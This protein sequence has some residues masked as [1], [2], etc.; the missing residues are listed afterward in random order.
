M[1][2]TLII[3]L[4]I[5][6]ILAILFYVFKDEIKK[7]FVQPTETI[8]PAGEVVEEAKQPEVVAQNLS[9]PWEL[10]FLPGGDM[11]VTERAGKLIR[12]GTDK[13]IIEIS[14]VTHKGEGGLLGLALHPNFK[15]NNYIYVYLTTTSSK[16][17]TN[18]VERYILV[19]E[20]L[21]ERKVIIENIPGA[22][23]HDGG[24]IAFGPDGFLYITTGDAGDKKNSQDK[25]SL[26][27]KT[28]RLTDEGEIP[29]DNPFGNEIYSY[30]HRNS[31]GIAWDSSGALWSTEHGPSGVGSGFDEVNKIVK[32]GNYGWPDVQGDESKTG[33]FSPLV[34]SGASETWAPSGMLIYRDNIFFV[35]LRG[36]TLYTSSI[37]NGKLGPLKSYFKNTY[38]RLR[39]VVLGPDNMFYLLTNNRDSLGKPTSAD[40]RIIKIDPK[41]L[42]L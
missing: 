19:G 29:A 1:K 10:V 39:T 12:I 21:S 17:L 35:G 28:L 14:G 13:K 11:L 7:M 4:S 3:V 15:S 22:T 41:T 5:L 33:M 9:I 25:K 34:Q 36:Q 2:K 37:S 42:G 31:Q 23:Y 40:D 18:R 30:G 32:G 24:R 27:G 20:V 26:A 16:G 38:G 6:C 8:I